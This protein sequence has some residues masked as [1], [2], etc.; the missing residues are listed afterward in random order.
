MAFQP[1][2]SAEQY[3]ELIEAVKKASTRQEM[4]KVVAAFAKRHKLAVSL[5]PAKG[6]T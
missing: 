6:P 5:D 3:A 1:S 2:L 4:Q